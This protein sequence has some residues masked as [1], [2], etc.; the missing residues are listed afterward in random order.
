MQQL[1]LDVNRQASTY[2]E[3]V[4]RG[5][6]SKHKQHAEHHKNHH[7]PTKSKRTKQQVTGARRVWGTRRS[8]TVSVVKDAIVNPANIGA[9][10]LQVERK[11]R[12][13]GEGRIRWWFVVHAEEET[14]QV[15]DATWPQ[16]VQSVQKHWK[17]EKYLMYADQTISEI[18]AA[19]SMRLTSYLYKMYT[20]LLLT[21][22]TVQEV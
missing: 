12:V 22:V 8:T 20:I 15:L 2:A 11:Y 13:I 17:L 14:L 6:G 5:S 19:I 1:Q 9:N 3:T 21:I 18:P 7:Q 16:S 10:E 4:K